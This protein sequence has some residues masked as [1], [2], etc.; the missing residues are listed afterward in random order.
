MPAN[1]DDGSKLGS[2]N[3]LADA[4]PWRQQLYNRIKLL[5]W[6]V[7]Y[8]RGA[9]SQ[10]VLRDRIMELGSTMG[11]QERWLGKIVRH[12]VSEFSKKG[13]GADY[14]GYHNIDH[15]LEAAYFA[16]L[17]AKNQNAA[18]RFSDE[19]ILYLF[20]AALFHDYDP[21]KA[22]DKPNEDSIERFIRGDAKIRRFIHEVGLN[23]DLVIA[24]IHRTAYP[25]RDEIAENA[26]KR[27][28][29]LFTD[30]GIPES[31]S[32][33]R[34]HYGDLGW[35]LSVAER[36]AGYALGDF[37]HSKDLA[38]RN[39]HA[40]G[41]HPSVINE[42]SVKYFDLLRDEKEMFD[43]V[44]EGVPIEYKEVFNGN[45]ETFRDTLM[46]EQELRDLVKNKLMMVSVVEKCGADLESYVQES[47]FSILRD[48]PMLVPLDEKNLSK[49]LG[50]E[51]SI[52]ITLR[53]NDKI[54]DIVGFAKGGPLEKCRL[55]R[56]T[57]DHNTGK[58]NTA[59]LEGIGIKHGFWGET[60]GHLLRIR[61]LEE[62]TKHGY[63][64]VS[65]YAHR[66]VIIQRITR[67]E[68]IQ[69]VQKYD[70]D[71]LDYYRADLSSSPYRM[72]SEQDGSITQVRS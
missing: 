19:D 71:K 67:G 14:Y 12:A 69:V 29:A 62:A 68:N 48:Q 37:E 31:D 39:A 60:G 13:L 45:V 42:R 47:I 32:A 58:G 26:T 64:F 50:T 1:Y 16:M 65:G 63:R 56:G 51:G 8:H 34:K 7:H 36:V 61:F 38:R 21:L 30:A 4:I 3:P 41:W 27:M 18:G 44:M 66:D 54:G 52:L 57:K 40:L 24:I 22:F 49:S 25:F 15:E 46:I 59:Y 20:V 43:R 23:V 10:A 6:W 17:A 70:P 2:M 55:R 35:F 11:L 28:D 33:T 72:I 5:P 9:T 53:I